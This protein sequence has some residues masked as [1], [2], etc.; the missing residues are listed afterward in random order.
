MAH[1]IVRSQSVPGSAGDSR[2]ERPLCVVLSIYVFSVLGAPLL[3]K[4]PT[5]RPADGFGYE[6]A[7]PLTPDLDDHSGRRLDL[8]TAGG[9]SVRRRCSFIFPIAGRTLIADTVP[10]EPAPSDTQFAR[11]RA[12]EI[13]S[14]LARPVAQQVVLRW[15]WRW[16]F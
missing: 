4:F 12:S 9:S 1:S 14:V 5:E 15:G 7:L 16:L 8:L 2:V 13:H 3:A 10:M 11:C 6:G